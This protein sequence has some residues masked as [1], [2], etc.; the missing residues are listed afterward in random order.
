[1]YYQFLSPEYGGVE[2]DEKDSPT[3]PKYPETYDELLCEIEGEN[4]LARLQEHRQ[5]ILRSKQVA[6]ETTEWYKK[7]QRERA[8]WQKFF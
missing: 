5:R 7:V 3:D 2:E 8:E 1:M 4:L 6:K